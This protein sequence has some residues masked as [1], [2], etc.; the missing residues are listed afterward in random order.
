LSDIAAMRD[1]DALVLAVS[2]ASYTTLS[3]SELGA[4]LK[5]GGV[6]ID[7]KSMFTPDA[8]PEGARYWSL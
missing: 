1:L 3:K 5:P 8:L 4:M 6:I 2:H 7:V